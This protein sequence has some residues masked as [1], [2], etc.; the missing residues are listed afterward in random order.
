MGYADENGE[1]EGLYSFYVI[2]QEDY[3]NGI[4]N[5]G[6]MGYPSKGIRDFFDN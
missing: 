5:G 4:F 1:I 3:N 2:T 6:H